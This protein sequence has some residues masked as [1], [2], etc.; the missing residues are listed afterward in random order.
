MKVNVYRL[1]TQHT[2]EEKIIERQIVKLKLDQL[3]VNKKMQNVNKNISKDQLK[4]MIQFGVSEIFKGE[5][6]TYTD[7][8]I[9]ELLRRG[10]EKAKINQI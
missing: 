8:D 4:D 3:C 6:G 7:E 5:N 1:I 10:E 2:I 9:D